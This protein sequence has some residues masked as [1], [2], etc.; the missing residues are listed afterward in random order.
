MERT[1][2]IAARAI[3]A[4]IRDSS[5]NKQRKVIPS[6]R[7][8]QQ[9][10][11]SEPAEKPLLDD[12]LPENKGGIFSGRRVVVGRSANLQ[13]SNRVVLPRKPPQTQSQPMVIVEKEDQDIEPYEDDPPKGGSR[14]KED[15]DCVAIVSGLPPGMTE[16]RLHSLCG[17]EVEV[18]T[19]Y[20]YYCCFSHTIIV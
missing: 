12:P 15:K 4:V 2:P 9:Q 6:Q 17:A 10:P 5:N 8:Q 11:N 3:S 13:T 19:Q 18:A 16:A 20:T 7:Q 1:A 14:P